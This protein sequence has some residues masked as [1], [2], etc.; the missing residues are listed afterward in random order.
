MNLAPARQH[1]F[2]RSFLLLYLCLVFHTGESLIEGTS[3]PENGTV[4]SLFEGAA[5][6]TFECSV[7]VDSNVTDNVTAL[8]AQTTW[9]LALA[10]GDPD[11]VGM[12]N[13]FNITIGGGV[14]Q[15]T[16]G[17]NLTRNQ[18]FVI[19]EVTDFLNGASIS[20]GAGGEESELATFS[21]RIYS[22]YQSLV[23]VVC[24]M[25]CVCVACVH[26]MCQ[27]A[28]VCGGICML[29][30]GKLPTAFGV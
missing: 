10:G 14:F 9:R 1:A 25:H 22:E 27:W 29:A 17:L 2:V 4:L 26:G 18:Y 24:G 28:F 5:N 19:S 6:V 23:C 30:Y 16:T 11:V 7:I 12:D 15:T 21:I 20:C 8:P 3:D 13:N